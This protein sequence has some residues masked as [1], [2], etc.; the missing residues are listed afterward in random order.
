MKKKKNQP[1]TTKCSSSKFSKSQT[2]ACV[3]VERKE[4]PPNFFLSEHMKDLGYLI[5]TPTQMGACAHV[6]DRMNEEC[7][8]H[9]SRE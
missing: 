2:N 1:K 8:G 7:M 5:Y 4:H 3:N 9:S 6:H